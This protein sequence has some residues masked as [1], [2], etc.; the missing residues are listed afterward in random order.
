MEL[1]TTTDYVMQI[2]HSEIYKR[3]VYR[4]VNRTTEV[5]EFETPMLPTA[6]AVIEELQSLLDNPPDTDFD[7]DEDEEPVKQ[8]GNM[9]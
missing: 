9:H 5:T 3:D 6:L 7:F 2:G 4:V 8:A 1:P